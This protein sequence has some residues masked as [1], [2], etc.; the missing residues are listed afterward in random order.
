MS[1][2]TLSRRRLL[3]IGAAGA[4]AFLASGCISPG[5]RTVNEEP[6]VPPADGEKVTLTHWS[7]LKDLQSVADQYTEVNPNV[8]VEVTWVP[9]ATDGAYQKMLSALAAGGGPDVGQIELR[10]VPEYVLAGGLVDL[11]RYGATEREQEFDPTGWS[12]L[13]I[14]GGIFGIPQDLG[15][16]AF[17]YQPDVL[18][19]VGADPPESWEKWAD[20]A[21]EVRRKDPSCYMD[22]FDPSDG[23]N[24]TFYAMQAGATWFIPDDDGWTVHLTDDVTLELAR[25]W[26]RVLDEELVNTGFAA[27]SSPWMAAA[28][29]G[30]I[31][32]STNGSWADALIEGVPDGAG[33]W[34]VAPMP[35]WE[36]GY[37]S[38]YRGGSACCVLANSEHPQEALDYLIWLHTSE[39]GLDGL[40]ERTG[41]GWSPAADYIGASRMQPSEFFS[42]QN[43]NQDVMVSMAEQQN[44]DWVWPPL[45]QQMFDI[46]ADGFRRKMT[47]GR[48]LVDVM[49]QAQGEI[50]QALR[51]KGLDAREGES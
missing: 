19:A 6:T 50:T 20:V 15:P 26:D 22:V 17:F 7:W 27:Y 51:D 30:K 41:I 38:G 14:S 5:A 29:D 12:R 45:T 21:R 2:P 13:A 35:R 43:Y 3:G 33:K 11:S 37:G 44:R 32:S 24:L 36:H 42:G 18:A 31:A 40:I 47:E 1:I 34:R 23:S 16:G 9:A 4:G 49:A 10:T 46:L 8:R 25:F 48:S 39:A 28:A